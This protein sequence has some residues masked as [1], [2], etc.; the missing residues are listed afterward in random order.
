MEREPRQRA[1][2]CAGPSAAPIEKIKDEYRWQLWYFTGSVSTKVVPELVKLQA[3]RASQWAED[4]T[5]V[6]DVDPVSLG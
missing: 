4:I 3:A 1:W 2:S 6:L 5:Q